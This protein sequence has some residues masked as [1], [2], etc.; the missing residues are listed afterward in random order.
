MTER[1][2]VNTYGARPHAPDWRGGVPEIRFREE[3]PGSPLPVK[4]LVRDGKA[5]STEGAELLEKKTRECA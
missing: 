1:I 4:I 2:V 3:L 5:L